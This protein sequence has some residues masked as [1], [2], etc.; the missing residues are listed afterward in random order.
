MLLPELPTCTPSDGHYSSLT[1]NNVQ[2]SPVQT[3]HVFGWLAGWPL[4]LLRRLKGLQ[5]WLMEAHVP[6]NVVYNRM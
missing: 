4:K 2:T 3:E 5:L 1:Q 6:P